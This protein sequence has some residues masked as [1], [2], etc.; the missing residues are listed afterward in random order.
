LK[1]TIL[2]P[3]ETT[4]LFEYWGKASCV[5]YDTVTN[6]P[7]KVG[8]GCMNSGHFS[9]SRGRYILFKVEGCP[10]F[11]IDQAVRH[12]DGVMKNVQSFRY[13]SK[14]SFAYEVPSEITDNE[15]LLKKYHNHMMKTMELY[16]EIQ[17]YVFKKTNSHERANEQA[18]YVLPISTHADFVIGM[19]VEALIHF[20]NSRL[21]VRA[22]DK[23]RELAKLLK[24]ATL[25]LLPEL[26]DKLVPN[27]QA[28]LWCPEGHASCGAYPTKKQL[29]QM[30][31]EVRANA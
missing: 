23:I 15:Q 14:D 16:T 6:T 1:V 2:N 27:C 10:R 8:K 9:G 21:C 19:T 22:E 29:K 17:D 24:E 4:R 5:C 11:C 31:A 30:I 12:E 13:V 28:L 7:E 26:K 3:E 20:A 25:E 18:R